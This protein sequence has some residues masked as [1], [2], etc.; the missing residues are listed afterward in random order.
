[1]SLLGLEF[2]MG[3]NVNLGQSS[4]TDVSSVFSKNTKCGLAGLG[5]VSQSTDHT[6]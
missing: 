6:A 1:M 5:V 4:D 3:R 2:S